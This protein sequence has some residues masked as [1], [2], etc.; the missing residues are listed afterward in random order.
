MRVT[1]AC[2]CL[3]VLN[4]PVENELAP[5]WLTSGVYALQSPIA[6]GRSPSPMNRRQRQHPSRGR[7]QQP[8]V[9]FAMQI[10]LASRANKSALLISRE[11]VASIV[12]D[13]LHDCAF[14]QSGWLVKNETPFFNARSPRIHTATV[15]FFRDR[16]I[17]QAVGFVVPN[18]AHLSRIRER[19]LTLQ[20]SRGGTE[21]PT[22]PRN[23]RKSRQSADPKSRILLASA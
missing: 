16:Q 14:G 8:A 7:R 18:R 4:R 17:D 9:P 2:A 6:A 11:I 15:R 23:R 19:S 13:K 5:A 20:R 1:A 12:D 22:H 3:E 10:D 21:T